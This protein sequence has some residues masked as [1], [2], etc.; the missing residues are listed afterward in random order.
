MGNNQRSVGVR[1]VV[2]LFFLDW[3][4]RA[5]VWWQY[6][7]RDFS[8]HSVPAGAAIKAELLHC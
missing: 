3:L 5:Q 4:K 1:Y 7:R 8:I 6:Y 2:E